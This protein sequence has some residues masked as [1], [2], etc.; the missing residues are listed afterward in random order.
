[1]MIDIHCHLLYGVDDG[2]KKIEESLDMLKAA[3][4]QGVDTIILTPHYRKGMFPYVQDKILVHMEELSFC[5]EEVGI[6]L[7][8]GTEHH[9][10]S[11]MIE[12]L[13][14]GR[15]Q[16]LCGSSYVLV[17][18]D[19]ACEYRY[20]WNVVQ[21]LLRNGYLPIIAHAER[22]HCLIEDMDGLEQLRRAGAMI[23]INAASV[24]GKE[25]IR[26]KK[27]CKT[28]LQN[29][30]ADLIASD[31]HGTK[32]RPSY[33]GKCAEYIG[34]KYGKEYAR[35]LF[36]INPSKIIGWENDNGNTDE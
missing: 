27:A 8:L 36:E 14:S 4:K 31:S 25:G 21:E 26:T 11:H 12:D 29:R 34:R 13:S 17:E 18:F 9:A 22:C 10:S 3:K 19:Y 15:C 32:V 5:A 28:I 1:M 30:L 2:P 6:S 16:T 33:M 23:Q 24:L 7:F 35:L 20:I